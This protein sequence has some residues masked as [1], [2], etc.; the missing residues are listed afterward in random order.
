MEYGF[1]GHKRMLNALL[2]TEVGRWGE[3]LSEFE[4]D[5][6]EF[7]GLVVVGD[8]AGFGVEVAH[9]VFTFELG[10]ELIGLALGDL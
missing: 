4:V 8:V 1:L 5:D 10:E 2:Q 3:D 7:P 9:P 6:V